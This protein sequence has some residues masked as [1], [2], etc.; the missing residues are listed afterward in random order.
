MKKKVFIVFSLLILVATA[1]IYGAKVYK[2]W[3]NKAHYYA[4]LNYDA[5]TI[6]KEIQGL[7]EK[8]LEKH[9]Q[10]AHSIKE[11]VKESQGASARLVDNPEAY[12]GLTEENSFSGSAYFYSI[13]EVS[14]FNFTAQAKYKGFKKNGEDIWQILKDGS[15]YPVV[16]QKFYKRK[17]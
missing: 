16:T 13:E 12:P 6:L 4:R 1:G 11:L 3:N 9:G 2:D 5:H 10:Y 7:Q 15:P 14:K 17:K 8:Y